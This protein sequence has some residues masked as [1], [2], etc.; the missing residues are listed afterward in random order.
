SSVVRSSL[1]GHH[2]PSTYPVPGAL[3]FSRNRGVCSGGVGCRP[4]SV[5]SCFGAMVTL[6]CWPRF[7]AGLGCVCDLLTAHRGFHRFRC[8]QPAT[9]S[10]E[11]VG[12]PPVNAVLDRHPTAT[13]DRVCPRT[14]TS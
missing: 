9:Q 1:C 6:L 12:R 13:T 7:V 11:S 5:R 14:R 10:C 4:T 2:A 3:G 8:S